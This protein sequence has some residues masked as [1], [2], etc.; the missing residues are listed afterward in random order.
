M[1][2]NRRVF[3]AQLAFQTLHQTPGD[4]P[5][6]PQEALKIRHR[7]SDSGVLVGTAAVIGR[8]EMDDGR[9]KMEDG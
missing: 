8:L 6:P 1:S 3:Q 9:L 2:S 4:P 7:A 5:R